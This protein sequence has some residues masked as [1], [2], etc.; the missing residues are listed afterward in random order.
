M[1][2]IINESAERFNQS[3]PGTDKLIGTVARELLIK[4]GKGESEVVN[5]KLK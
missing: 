4:V 3:T 5:E 2:A 1:N